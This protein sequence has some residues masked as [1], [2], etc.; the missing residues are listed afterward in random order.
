MP[1]GG[2]DP[3]GI[4]LMDMGAPVIPGTPMTGGRG[5]R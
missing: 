2:T 5:Q 4:E 3:D 1:D